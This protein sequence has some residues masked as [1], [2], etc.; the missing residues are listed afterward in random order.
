MIL[1]AGI[2]GKLGLVQR[3]LRGALGDGGWRLES[4][5]LGISGHDTDERNRRDDS[6]P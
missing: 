6:Q 2:D 3:M 5:D 1:V 4:N